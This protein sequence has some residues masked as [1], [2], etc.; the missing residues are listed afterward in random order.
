MIEVLEIKTLAESKLQK[1]LYILAT[2]K[3]QSAYLWSF[4][5]PVQALSLPIN[6]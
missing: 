3:A 1:I 4:A 2:C 5:T 6:K